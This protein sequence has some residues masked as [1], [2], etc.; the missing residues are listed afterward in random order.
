MPSGEIEGKTEGA[1]EGNIKGNIEGTIDDDIDIEGN[2]KGDIEGKIESEGSCLWV[3]TIGLV[4]LHYMS[5]VEV[6][7][8]E[9]AWVSK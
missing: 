3:G 4:P 9:Y 8:M 1:M 6:D 2:I 5:E 7:A